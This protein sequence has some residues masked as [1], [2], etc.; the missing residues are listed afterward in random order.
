MV[1][2]GI[3]VGTIIAVKTNEILAATHGMNIDRQQRNLMST[4]HRISTNNVINK[5]IPF[6]RRRNYHHTTIT[7]DAITLNME[8]IVIYLPY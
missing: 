2:A 4:D 7:I 3:V 6:N 5:I 8:M 1:P